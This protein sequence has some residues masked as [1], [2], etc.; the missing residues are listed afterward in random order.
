MHLTAEK[1]LSPAQL[2]AELLRWRL[3]DERIVF[4]NGCFDLLHRGHVEYLEK[5]KALGNRLVIGLN[6]DRSPWFLKKGSNR[7]FVDEKSR[8]TLLA[9]LQSVDAVTLFDEESPE[10]LIQLVRP[11][12]LVKGGDY[13]PAQVVGSA[14]ILSYGGK[15]DI[16]PLSEGFSTSA[17]IDKIKNS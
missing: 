6:S 12:V 16:V 9:A 10:N 2:Q 11:D 7:P 3:K 14:W 4:T 17:L 15:I 5:A 8:A 1:I 13:L